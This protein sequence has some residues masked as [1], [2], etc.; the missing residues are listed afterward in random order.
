MLGVGR[1]RLS[2]TVG[3][4]LPAEVPITNSGPQ[5]ATEW[6]APAQHAIASARNASVSGLTDG[7]I[8]RK[9]SVL[10][11]D[12]D[13]TAQPGNLGQFGRHDRQ[14]ITTS[15]SGNELLASASVEVQW[16]PVKPGIGGIDARAPVMA[17]V[18]GH[19]VSPPSVIATVKVRSLKRA[20]PSTG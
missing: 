9:N 12:H 14:P 11:E 3:A 10:A 17:T 8:P 2:S 4:Q 16:R 1:W 18:E 19:G 5:W 7:G 20:R 6:P 15:R 13:L